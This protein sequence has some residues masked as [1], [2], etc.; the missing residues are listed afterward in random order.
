[1]KTCQRLATPF[2]FIAACWAV[3][4]LSG[5]LDSGTSAP[6]DVTPAGP[7]LKALLQPIAES[8][9]V[10][11]AGADL[12][13]IAESRP[14]LKDDITALMAADGNP[15]QVKQKANALLGRL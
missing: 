6:V 4:I 10:G 1:V 2:V 8:G 7:D 15:E 11:S 14:E 13:S 3:P 12:E 5:C 9:E